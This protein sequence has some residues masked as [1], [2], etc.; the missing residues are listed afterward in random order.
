MRGDGEKKM[1]AKREKSTEV[2]EGT[3][4]PV[5]VED[6]LAPVVPTYALRADVQEH[7]VTLFGMVQAARELRHELLPELERATR[8][9]ELWIERNK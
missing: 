1:K 8:E 9:F 2:A 6:M 3:N 4:L 5:V 7:R